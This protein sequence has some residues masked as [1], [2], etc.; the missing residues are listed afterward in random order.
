MPSCC[1]SFH[2]LLVLAAAMLLLVTMS[3]NASAFAPSISTSAVTKTGIRPHQRT[4]PLVGSFLQASS[5]QDEDSSPTTAPPRMDEETRILTQN[6]KSP[7]ER[8]HE[9]WVNQIKDM[10]TKFWDY[11]VIFSYIGIS[12]L[13]LLN[14]LGYGYSFTPQGLQ[15][16][17]LPEYI[18]DRQWKEELQRATVATATASQQMRSTAPPS[19]VSAAPAAWLLE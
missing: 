2:L 5:L 14:V 10:N 19:A 17:P 4:P 3:S 7:Q 11:T 16:L 1:R 12:C 6:R 8:Q 15:V 9:L 13:I 18:Q